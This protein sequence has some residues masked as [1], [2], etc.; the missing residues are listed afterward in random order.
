M[1]DAFLSYIAYLQGSQEI[2]NPVL[3]FYQIMNAHTPFQEF[4]VLL[5]MKMLSIVIVDTILKF[6]SRYY[7][8]VE[9]GLMVA[10][11]SLSVLVVIYDILL[12]IR[13]F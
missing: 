3:F 10:I 8:K 2:Y 1:S 4:L 6:I 11:T 5:S 12:L 9:L 7:P 13:F